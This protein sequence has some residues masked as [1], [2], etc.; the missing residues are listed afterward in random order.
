[1]ERLFN[2]WEKATWCFPGMGGEGR[3][4]SVMNF[5]KKRILTKQKDWLP[6]VA[7][8]VD[9]SYSLTLCRKGGL[10]YNKRFGCWICQFTSSTIPHSYSCLIVFAVVSFTVIILKCIQYQVAVAVVTFVL[11]E[12]T[13]WRQN[14]ESDSNAHH[15]LVS[16]GVDFVKIVISCK[17]HYITDV[18]ERELLKDSWVIIYDHHYSYR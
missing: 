16:V 6:T 11:T 10:V 8:G 3:R 12:I 17:V 14:K 15:S 1:M 9:L 7:V 2:P 13:H 18:M 5:L 4:A